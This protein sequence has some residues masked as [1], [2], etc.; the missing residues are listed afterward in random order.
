MTKQILVGLEGSASGQT[1]I[2]L[3]I[4]PAQF[5]RQRDAAAE[6]LQQRSAPCAL[7]GEL[8][9]VDPPKPMRCVAT[10][11]D[12]AKSYDTIG[13]VNGSNWSASLIS[14]SGDEAAS[15]A[16]YRQFETALK[17]VVNSDLRAR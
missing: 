5:H 3:A 15:G 9:L 11:P 16:N 1:A 13:I 6:V 14:S 10:A 8:A 17:A 4:A 12:G 2:Q 7:V